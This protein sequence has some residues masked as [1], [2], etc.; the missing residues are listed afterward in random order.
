[1]SKTYRSDNLKTMLESYGKFGLFSDEKLKACLFDML[2]FLNKNDSEFKISGFIKHMPIIPS[3]KACVIL[4]FDF[5][6]ATIVYESTLFMP[7]CSEQEYFI[8]FEEKDFM[9]HLDLLNEYVLKMVDHIYSPAY[10][11]ICI[12]R[13]GFEVKSFVNTRKDGTFELSQWSDKSL[14]FE[15]TE[16]DSIVDVAGKVFSEME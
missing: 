4:I 15:R 8:R 5:Q 7:L 13:Q 6:H 3:H 10:E 11:E 16:F 9:T 12:E 14:S 1:M 2:A